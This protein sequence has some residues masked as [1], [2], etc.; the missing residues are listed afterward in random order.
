MSRTA[1]SLWV[2]VFTVV[3]PVGL[4]P[5]TPA[6]TVRK[7]PTLEQQQKLDEAIQKK[8]VA[9]V[10]VLDGIRDSKLVEPAAGDDAHRALLRQRLERASKAALRRLNLFKAGSA[11]G[12]ILDL[13]ESIQR[14]ADA[15]LA[16]LD[17][18]AQRVAALEQVVVIAAAIEDVNGLRF[19]EGQIPIQDL[20]LSREFHAT[21]RL[22]VL[23]AK[24]APVTPRPKRNYPPAPPLAPKIL[25]D[26]SPLS[27]AELAKEREKFDK[28]MHELIAKL[29]HTF[30][31]ET[32]VAPAPGDD[33]RRR[34]L[35]ARHRARLRA[36]REFTDQYFEGVGGTLDPLLSS[37]RPLAASELALNDQPA[38]KLAVAE[39]EV[40]FTRGWEKVT[41]WV[42]N[43]GRI[44]ISDFENPVRYH[45]LTAEIKLLELRAQFPNV[46]VVKP[47]PPAQ[48]PAGQPRVV[49][50]LTADERAEIKTGS[51]SLVAEIEGWAGSGGLA[52]AIASAEATLRQ[53]QVSLYRR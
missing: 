32:L 34:L 4:A 53:F 46:A 42:F 3:S 28:E 20:H 27:A 9:V 26:V 8:L 15:E 7:A 29:R 33:E 11:R 41:M 47:A 1:H 24:Q 19:D 22:A 18:P 16:L 52:G 5:F 45:C 17:Q 48:V 51:Y 35:K 25:P 36:T 44:P 13:I 30:D 12:T 2:L 6:Q 40:Q 14:L 38:N 37:L 50:V 31:D 23:D 10:A 49:P 39:R 21:C 43:S